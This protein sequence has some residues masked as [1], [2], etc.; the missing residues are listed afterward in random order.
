MLQNLYR[1]ANQ[2]LEQ[3]RALHSKSGAVL[4]RAFPRH[5]ITP[6]PIWNIKIYNI[7]L[8]SFN[9]TNLIKFA[10]F[11]K[12]LR[13][14]TVGRNWRPILLELCP[15]TPESIARV[16]KMWTGELITTPLVII[17]IIIFFNSIQRYLYSCAREESKMNL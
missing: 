11:S 13:L 15:R 17:Q 16:R 6:K 5:K 4:C 1:L 8:M 10:Y 14:S 9:D 7:K 12:I 3:N 2:T